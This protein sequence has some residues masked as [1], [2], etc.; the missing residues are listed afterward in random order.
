MTIWPKVLALNSIGR[1][2]A[3]IRR[4]A[5]KS[6]WSTLSLTRLTK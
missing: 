4:A 3:L 5:A 2:A 6:T 1:N